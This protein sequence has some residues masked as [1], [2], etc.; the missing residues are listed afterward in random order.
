MA[1]NVVL[2]RE[3]EKLKKMLAELRN[4][5]EEDKKQRLEKVRYEKMPEFLGQ[6]G[7]ET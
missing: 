1:K 5:R 6:K 2:S 3:N 7:K 4:D